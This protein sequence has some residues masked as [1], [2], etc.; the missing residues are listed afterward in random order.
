MLTVAKLSLWSVNYYNDT[1]RAVGDA[2]GD[3][4]RAN[5]G[6]AEYYAERDTRT[7]VWACAGDARMA[8]ELVGLDDGERAG[9]DADPEVVAR[10]LDDGV[11][12]SGECGRA[13]GKSGV[14]GFDLT[15][16]APKSVSL[17][18]VFGDEVID[19]AVSAAHQTAIGEALEYLAAHAGYTRVHNPVTGEKDLVKLPGLVAAAYQH[20]TSRAGDPHLHTHVLVPNRQA[21]AD[22]RLVSI[23]GTSLFHE[24]RAAGI[25]YQA[26][27]RYELH[28]LTG[29]EWGPVDSA[30]GMAEIAGIDPATIIAWSQRSTQLRQWAASNLTVVDT[31]EDLSQAQLAAAQK[32]TRPRKPESVSWPEL[33]AQWRADSRGLAVSRTAQ[34]E[35]RAAREQAARDAAARLSRGRPVVDRR[36]V[37][38]MAA[39]A[40]KAALT[41]ADL[42]EVIGAQLPLMSADAAGPDSGGGSAGAGVG[43]P[44]QLIEAAVDTVGMRLTGPPLAHQRE[45]SARYTVDLI[46]AEERRVFDLVDATNMRA[47]AWVRPEHTAAAL[48]LSDQQHQVVTAIAATPQLVV[49]LSA[50]AGAGKTTSMRALRSI[51][52]RRAK[53]RMIVLAPT[54]KAVDV[55]IAEGAA[56]EGYTMHSALARLEDGRLQLGPFDV[57]VVD[58]AGMVG[59]DHWRHLLTHTTESGTKTVLVGD[60]HQLEPVKARGGMFAQLCDELPWTQRLSEVWRMR[61]PAERAASLALRD[62]GPAPVRRAINWYRDHQRLACGDQVTMAADAFAAHRADLTAGK[63]TLLLADTVEICDALNR[64][65]HDHTVAERTA[66]GRDTATVTGARGHHIA[67]GDVVITRRNDPTITVY[68][69]DDRTETLTDAPVRNGQRWRVVAVDDTA[70]APRIAVRRIGD[71]AWAVF[72]RDYLREQVQLG[73]AVTVHAAQGVTADTTH[74]VLAETASRNL[75]YVA[76]T[77]GRASN[78]AY[79]YQR[80]PAETDHTHS[81]DLAGAEGVQG[82]HMARRGTPTDAARALRQVI[83][84]DDPAHTA[85][86]IAADTPAQ[87]LP[88]RVASLVA[89]H[90]RTLTQRRNTYQKTQ[91]AQ[92]DRALDRD[93]GLDRSQSREQEHGYDLSL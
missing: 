24:A 80:D 32:A 86:Q 21:R 67:T 70:E 71:G 7:P 12:P 45:G 1:A 72:D 11:A 38:A 40:D 53:A 49:P 3:R 89:E 77:R 47:M 44:R 75:A 35:A 55:A 29:I 65:V 76:L 42:V 54:G 58:E 92:R 37:A 90:Q 15:F 56:S 93:L 43:L 52:E 60:A 46:L 41:R 79:L 82:V 8:A 19:K 78:H 84:R 27:L 5:G 39:R 22:G 91:R 4:Q 20:E 51:V 26:T 63:D 17:V 36:A 68:E 23:D 73:H 18:R 61:D 69:A 66:A 62:G 57:V 16:C 33:R 83:G 64:R 10:W 6:L 25:I 13:H 2:I 48:G 34:R 85:H 30:T 59:T 74:T 28:R 88:D 14:H 50:P 9:G 31:A 81:H 87:L